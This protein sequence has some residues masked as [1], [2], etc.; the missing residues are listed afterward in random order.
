LTLHQGI[1]FLVNPASPNLALVTTLGFDLP[2]EIVRGY[3]VPY[4]LPSTFCVA[5]LLNLRPPLFTDSL[6][7]S[8]I[9]KEKSAGILEFH[10]FGLAYQPYLASSS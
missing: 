6:Y 9:Q 1:G 3:F 4:I 7:L 5:V 8:P 2:R 10:H